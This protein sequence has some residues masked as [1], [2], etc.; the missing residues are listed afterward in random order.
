MAAERVAVVCPYYFFNPPIGTP[1]RT[2]FLQRWRERSESGDLDH[3]VMVSMWVI[4][5]WLGVI[6]AG[7]MV[8]ECLYTMIGCNLHLK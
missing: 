3:C 7:G 6:L 5:M 1:Q 2:R 4:W 8:V